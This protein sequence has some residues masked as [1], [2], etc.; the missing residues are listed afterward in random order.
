MENGE[1][2][3]YLALRDAMSSIG[4]KVNLLAVVVEHGAPK[5]TKGTDY[6]LTLKIMDASYRDHGF[7][8][9]FFI[10]K[11][12]NMPIIKSDGDIIYLRRVV[13]KIYDGVV[14]ALFNKK[15]STFALFEGK[16]GEG[17]KPYQVSSKIQIT[18]H[19]KEYITQLRTWLVDYQLDAGVNSYLLQMREI[20]ILHVSEDLEG[21]W[22][23]FVWDGTDAPPVSFQTNLD[24]E[25]Q[26][27]LP[28]HLEPSP[29]SRDVLCKFPCVGTVLRIFANN[30]REEL[31]L[32]SLG[33]GQWVKF[34][35]MMFQSQSGLWHGLLT[36]SSRLS[37]LSDEDNTV[38]HCERYYNERL[39]SNLNNLPLSSFPWPSL[40]TETDHDHVAFS[41]LMDVLTY[42]KV[43]QKFKCVVRVVALLPWRAEDF[44][45]PEGTRVY[46]IRLTLEDPTA[47]IHAYVFAEDG[48]KFFEG[49]PPPDTLTRKM[50][51]L[52][53]LTESGSSEDSDNVSRNPPWVQCCIKSYYLVKSN[54]WETRRYRIFGTKL[55]Q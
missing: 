16:S 26:N 9:N 43:T 6:V 54:P 8:V 41:T 30:P 5:K 4:Q 55:V 36:P 50:N 33:I 39:S 32:R 49:Y 23:L 27:P 17:F 35:K 3:V 48:V 18:N 20:K 40:I 45:S 14:Y 46:R 51:K 44:R 42:S 21:N 52:L 10:D 28:L 12:D 7:S 34:H 2:Y 22:V 31:G 1:G 47:R 29:L 53:G 37:A 38:V 19:D 15:F 11:I 13:M 24:A 25:A